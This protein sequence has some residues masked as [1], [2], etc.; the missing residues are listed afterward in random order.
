MTLGVQPGHIQPHYLHFLTQIRGQFLEFGPGEPA[1]HGD[2]A[3]A[4]TKKM[5]CYSHQGRQRRD[6]SRYKRIKILIGPVIFDTTVLDT[7]SGQ[8]EPGPGLAQE[9]DAFDPTV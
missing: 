1:L 6:C 7:D 5:F 3:H 4:V 2:Q 9:A 8:P